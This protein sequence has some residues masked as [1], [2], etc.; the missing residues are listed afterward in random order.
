MIIFRFLEKKIMSSLPKSLF[1]AFLMLLNTWKVQSQTILNFP[2]ERF[3]IQRDTSNMALVNFSGSISQVV[4]SL[5]ISIY[6]R[7]TLETIGH[8]KANNNSTLG[9]FDSSIPLKGGWY[10]AQ[11]NAYKKGRIVDF[12]RV[13]RFGVGEVFVIAG[14]SNAQGIDNY[15]GPSSID[16][17]VNVVNHF[18]NNN[19]ENIP[20]NIFVEHL[21][22]NSR[23][24]PNGKSAWCWGI[25]GDSLSKKL[26]VPVLFFNAAQSGT[27]SYNWYQSALGIPTQDAIFQNYFPLGY[28]YQNLKF[29]LKYY[30]SIFGIRSVLWHQG[31]TDTYPGRPNFDDTF[32]HLKTVINKSR[33]DFGF[34][35]PWLMSRVSYVD[36]R[37]STEII[38][39]QNAIIAEP[40]YNVFEGP[41]TD[42][43]QIPRPDGVHF[44][45]LNGANGLNQLANAWLESLNSN[46]FNKAKSKSANELIR[47]DIGCEYPNAKITAPSGYKVYNWYGFGTDQVNYIKNSIAGATLID[48]KGNFR[49]SYKYDLWVVNFGKPT[50]NTYNK[51]EICKGDSVLIEAGDTWKNIL[52]NTGETTSTI[53]AKADQTYFYSAQNSID[54]PVQ[55]TENIKLPEVQIPNFSL[56][57][58][59]PSDNEKRLFCYGDSIY[60]EGISSLGNFNWSN[61]ST[62]NSFYL[63]KSDTLSFYSTYSNLN[64]KTPSTQKIILFEKALAQAPKI[65]FDNSRNILSSSIAENSHQ[66]FLNDSLLVSTGNE[67]VP[68]LDGIYTLKTKDSDNCLSPISE[69]FQ[70]VILKNESNYLN[71]I[72]P[73][74]A[75]NYLELDFISPIQKIEIYDMHGK[76]VAFR[77]FNN[78]TIDISNLQPGS[79]LIKINKDKTYRFIKN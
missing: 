35:I 31:E 19:F 47:L 50:V 34:N 59:K 5:Q 12:T 42:S 37:F 53:W 66:W 28:P 29:A 61:G 73:I 38:R 70:L 72:F 78:Q 15:G 54:C 4:D 36:Y 41:Y 74:P 44:S 75:D 1:F 3:V 63:K 30:A 51:N 11:I 64:C 22:N 67:I 7:Q 60:V 18:F 77:F 23:I 62:K 52:W 2:R 27:L 46:F 17:R 39:A 8:Y 68:N 71:K 26:D 43:L 79:Y 57:I 25:L 16:D 49:L 20:I 55:T 45:N 24:S 13:E 6:D 21:E 32:K 33:E 40:N 14:Q 76:A 48:E 56:N 9:S 58:F 69:P 65:N 10:K